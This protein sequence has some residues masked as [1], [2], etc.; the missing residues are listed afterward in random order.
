MQHTHSYHYLMLG[1]IIGLSGCITIVQGPVTTPSPTPNAAEVSLTP[2]ESPVEG[3]T[4]TVTPPAGEHPEPTQAPD[5]TETEAPVEAT[6]TAA[7][8]EPTPTAVP[9]NSP[10]PPLRVDRDQDGYDEDEDCD[11]EDDAIHPGATEF[12]DGLDDDCDGAIDE[13]AVGSVPWYVDKDGDF[14]GAK[15]PAILSC[16]IPEVGMVTNDQDCD[17][18][19]PQVNS[20]SIEICNGIDD[21]CDQQIDTDDPDV[22]GSIPYYLD[23]DEDGYGDGAKMIVDCTLPAGYSDNGEDCNDKNDAINPDQDEY[24]GNNKDDDCDGVMDDGC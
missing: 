20:H 21:D 19:N 9:E 7:S 15:T 12:C 10:T 18:N 2:T 13:D 24:C 6:A 1:A 3:L 17:D 8:P 14:H 11:D 22:Y 23:L 4:A 16:T 5:P